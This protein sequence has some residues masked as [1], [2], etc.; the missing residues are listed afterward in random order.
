M[1]EHCLLPDRCTCAACRADAY[2]ERAEAAEAKLAAINALILPM[3]DSEF[4][5]D[6]YE[7]LVSLYDLLHGKVDNE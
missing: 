3:A 4:P 1:S 2:K 5:V 6:A 7:L